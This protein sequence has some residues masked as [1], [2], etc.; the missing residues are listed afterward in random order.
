[1]PPIARK[2]FPQLV[3]AS[4]NEGKL[5]EMRQFLAPLNCPLLDAKGLNLPEVEETGHD[6]AANAALKAQDATNRTG[7]PALGDD[8]GL[9]IDALDGRPGI[10]SARFAG[11]QRDFVWA[12]KK[13]RRELEAKQAL[14]S[15]AHFICVLALARPDKPTR[16]YT[17]IVSGHTCFPPRG[18]KGFGYDPIFLPLG[19]KQTFGEMEAAQ[20]DKISHRAEAMRAFLAAMNI[21]HPPPP[22]P[23][24]K[25]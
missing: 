5:A 25:A 3:L 19:H 14:A 23:E 9:A 22:P 10:Y 8:S 12:A 18:N 15:P 24:S 21:P 6:F 2:I 16:C 17:G 20:K 13:L 4:T 7:L 11:P 1:M